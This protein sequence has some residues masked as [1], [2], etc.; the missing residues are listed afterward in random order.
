MPAAQ[1]RWWHRARPP[2]TRLGWP[3]GKSPWCCGTALHRLPLP[4]SPVPSRRRPRS[5]WLRLS[6]SCRAHLCPRRA[7]AAGSVPCCRDGKSGWRLFHMSFPALFVPTPSRSG[8]LPCSYH[9][10]TASHAFVTTFPPGVDIQHLV[11]QLMKSSRSQH[12]AQ[13]SSCMGAAW[14]LCPGADLIPC[15]SGRSRASGRQAGGQQQTPGQWFRV[16]GLSCHAMPAP[17]GSLLVH[18]AP[19]KCVHASHSCLLTTAHSGCVSCPD[20]LLLP[21]ARA[22]ASPE[23]RSVR[24]RFSMPDAADIT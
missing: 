3:G 6:P 2:L 24:A 10:S 11:P 23:P 19:A 17:M 9:G 21:S 22:A 13:L 12:R 20:H 1:A 5:C 15:M 14:H 18:M 16:S 4:R 7:G 8:F